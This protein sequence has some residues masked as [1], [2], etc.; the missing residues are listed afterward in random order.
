M[1]RKRK[2]GKR[3]ASGRLSRSLD[4]TF[5]HGADHA[6]ARKERY[7]TNGADAI[8]RAYVHGYLGDGNEA[9]LRLDTSRK[10]QR[11]YWRNV[12]AARCALDDTPR[13]NSSQ[14]PE[15]IEGDKWA[16]TFVSMFCQAVNRMG[17]D[18]RRAFDQLVIDPMP[19]C[20]PEWLD[21]LIAVQLRWEYDVRRAES[22]GLEPPKE[23]G[24]YWETSAPLAKAL[25]A[26]DKIAVF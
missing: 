13:G 6:R 22:Q 21:K 5:D 16:E 14:T 2:A 25:A 20:G 9:K 19:D 24:R 11:N 26:L 1:A 3:T 4:A 10:C 12:P 15:Q 7:G 23:L 18:Y 8:G 17:P